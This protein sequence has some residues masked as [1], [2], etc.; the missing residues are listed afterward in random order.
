MFLNTPNLWSSDRNP[1]N[2]TKSCTSHGAEMGTRV[3]S[4]VST[5]ISS[6]FCLKVYCLLLMTIFITETQK[7]LRQNFIIFHHIKMHEKNM[8]VNMSHTVIFCFLILMPLLVTLQ[9]LQSSP[10]FYLLY[11]NLLFSL[12]YFF[13]TLRTGYFN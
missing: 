7:C 9:H 6:R 11:S 13:N 12:I 10:Q 1:T 5:I 4:P 3:S 8:E 2:R